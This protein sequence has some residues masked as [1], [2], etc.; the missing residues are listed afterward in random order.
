MVL[1]DIQALAPTLFCAVPRVFDRIH[2]GIYEQV[3]SNRCHMQS[4]L[5]CAMGGG[6]AEVDAS[7]PATGG[8]NPDIPRGI[9]ARL[10][11]APTPLAVAV[12]QVFDRL[13]VSLLLYN[14]HPAAA[15]ELHQVAGVHNLRMGQVLLDEARHQ[16]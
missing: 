10:V 14:S 2:A 16:A 7:V 4:K 11:H 13:A 9:S 8:C 3:S 1:D 5:Y 12:C 6:K 15:E